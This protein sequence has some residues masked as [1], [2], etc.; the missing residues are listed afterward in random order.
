MV[1]RAGIWATHALPHTRVSARHTLCSLVAVRR[2]VL[3]RLCARA[4]LRSR[5]RP[6]RRTPAVGTG[7][8]WQGRRR[9]GG[10]SAYGGGRRRCPRTAPRPPVAQ[11]VMRWGEGWTL[12][13]WAPWP[14]RLPDHRVRRVCVSGPSLTQG[15][16][17]K[18]LLECGGV[19]PNPGPCLGGVLPLTPAMLTLLALPMVG[20]GDLWLW[21]AQPPSV[22][23]PAAAE[24]PLSGARVQSCQALLALQCA[25]ACGKVQAGV[26]SCQ[27]PALARAR[28]Q[29]CKAL[30]AHQRAHASGG[31]RPGQG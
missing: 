20:L 11:L 15:G 18:A 31:V 6:L 9:C 21:A 14:L 25:R 10:G 3:I 23:P 7:G 12:R 28:A 16:K 27:A 5:L 29:S 22:W 19:E 26:Q 13:A 1:H 2:T 24:A 17:G 4:L 8:G 30:M